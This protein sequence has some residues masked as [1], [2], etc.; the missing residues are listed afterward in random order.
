MRLAFFGVTESFLSMP[1]AL[2]LL[3]TGDREAEVRSRVQGWFRN[4]LEVLIGQKSCHFFYRSMES[5]GRWFQS[6]ERCWEGVMAQRQLGT[7]APN[8]PG[9]LL[10]GA[11]HPW[12]EL[13]RRQWCDHTSSLSSCYFTVFLVGRSPSKLKNVIQSKNTKDCLFE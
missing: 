13:E 11:E 3:R 1:N 7:D 6:G 9:S 5:L 12:R 4:S 8:A 10:D 2:D